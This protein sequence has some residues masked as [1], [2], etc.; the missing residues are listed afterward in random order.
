MARGA[1][2]G[3]RTL[4]MMV[5]PYSGAR[6]ASSW[7]A[8]GG[9]ETV[10]ATDILVFHS[11]FDVSGYTA[12]D[13][14]L[15]PLGV[16]LQDPGYYRSSN[17]TVPL[18]V[19]DIISTET[20]TPEEAYAWITAN[21]MPGMIGTTSDWNQIIWGQYRTMLGQATFQAAQT[22]FLTARAGLFGSGS[23]TTAEKIHCYRFLI[24]EGALEPDT[25]SV[26]ASRF[27]LSAIIAGEDEKAFLMRQKRS[28]ELAT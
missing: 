10:A 17:A 22:E 18:A 26:P 25:L 2:E 27:V 13:L 9:W 19:V 4:S 7:S 24:L 3:E 14:T 28:Y 1:L 8:S 5:P 20:I 6:G 16:T 23:P 12:D 11:W 15:F 21:A